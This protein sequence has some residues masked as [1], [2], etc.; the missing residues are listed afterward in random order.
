MPV[1]GHV[2][3]AMYLA[4]GVI[5]LLWP[6]C[7]FETVGHGHS[8][9]HKQVQF[10]DFSSILLCV[11]QR[12]PRANCPDMQRLRH[13]ILW[14]T[15]LD[16]AVSD[17]SILDHVLCCLTSSVLGGH[18]K[19][20]LGTEGVGFMLVKAHASG[21]ST[22]NHLLIPRFVSILPPTQGIYRSNIRKQKK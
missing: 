16:C 9:Y 19:Q 5:G 11:C 20:C 4:L 21:S 12:S 15:L 17:F 3:L 22:V 7:V 2:Y 14:G 10:F 18:S 8:A 13:R 6:V 1:A